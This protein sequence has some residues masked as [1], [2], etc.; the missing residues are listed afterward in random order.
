VIDG[1]GIVED[2]DT[3]M[4]IGC[5]L[6]DNDRDVLALCLVNIQGNTYKRAF[7]TPILVPRDLWMKKKSTVQRL[8][9]IPSNLDNRLGWDENKHSIDKAI[10]FRFCPLSRRAYSISKTEPPGFWDEQSSRLLLKQSSADLKGERV[11][12]VILYIVD[13]EENLKFQIHVES[14]SQDSLR[15]SVISSSEDHSETVCLDDGLLNQRCK[16]DNETFDFQARFQGIW[17]GELINIINMDIWSASMLKNS[18]VR[19]IRESAEAIRSTGL[20][21]GHRDESIPIRRSSTCPIPQL[22]RANTSKSLVQ[23]S[24]EK[25]RWMFWVT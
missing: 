13:E 10:I 19:Q 14:A 15:F 25:R 22:M 17:A 3:L 23:T 18:M 2:T 16:V 6:E 21:R 1:T 9:I 5:H 12:N 24:R 11:W 7:K 4:A 20:M 8:F